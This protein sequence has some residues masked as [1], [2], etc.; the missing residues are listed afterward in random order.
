MN[1]KQIAALFMSELLPR[2]QAQPGLAAV[3]LA[4]KYQPR[5][6]GANTGPIVY[7]FKIGDHNHGSPR[8]EDLYN[9]A[10]VIFD[11]TQ[12]QLVE[13]T[14]QLAA[15][16]PQNPADVAALTESDVLNIVSAIMQSDA[17]LAA[18]RGAGVGIQRVTDIR[19]PYF[20]D[21]RDRFEAE[22]SFDIVLTHYRNL[23]ST[24]PA[25]DTFEANIHR[26]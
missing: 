11:Q 15:W 7:F 2:M 20:V 25:V 18:F 8:R 4:R 10:G 5:Q 14:Y 24:L 16:V 22:P 12:R 26:V 1:D 9:E 17:I 6:H 23:S 3:A 19:N 13:T 21:E